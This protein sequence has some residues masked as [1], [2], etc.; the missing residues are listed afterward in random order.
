MDKGDGYTTEIEFLHVPSWN[1][2]TKLSNLFAGH[3]PVENY[4]YE[5]GDKELM[6]EQK[7]SIK[8]CGLFGKSF[9]G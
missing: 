8:K 1:D 4:N 7:P 5:L 2:V 3:Q 9:S 6:T